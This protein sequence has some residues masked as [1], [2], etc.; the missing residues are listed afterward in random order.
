MAVSANIITKTKDSV[1]IVPPAAVKTVGG[2]SFV[3]VIKDGKQVETPVEIGLSS[4]TTIEITSGIAEG[5]TIV[6]SVVAQSTSVQR[7]STGASPFG[8]VGGGLFRGAA[9]GAARGR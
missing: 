7:A 5:D 1:L 2:Q 8:A 9:G 3:R 4:D 6:T